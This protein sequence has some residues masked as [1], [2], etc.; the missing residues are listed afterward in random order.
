[1]EAVDAHA[2]GRP[3]EAVP[4][5]DGE[6][7]TVR[8][9]RE[10]L[11][12]LGLDQ[13]ALAQLR[14]VHVTGTKG[15]GSTCALVAAAL[16]AAG[17]PRVGLY[18]SP[19]LLDVRERIRVSGVPISR[20]AFARCYARVAGVLGPRG[21]LARLGY[22]PLLTVMA[23]EHFVRRRC[24]AV[25]L[26]VGVG[27]R[28]DATNVID[29]PAVC[30]VASLG[31]D[32]TAALG[33]TAADIAW[34]KA[35]IFRPHVPALSAPGQP[36]AAL[37]VL[38][39]RA[40]QAGTHLVVADS[41]A[42]TAAAAAAHMPGAFQRTNAALAAAIVRAWQQVQQ[43]QGGAVLSEEDVER[44]IAAALRDCVWPG[45]AQTLVYGSLT[46]R[47]DGAHTPESIAAC[48]EWFASSTA[49]ATEAKS[50]E[51]EEEES[52]NAL[53]FACKSDRAPAVLLGC[54]A[55]ACAAHG[56]VFGTVL[57]V[58]PQ[59]QRAFHSASTLQTAARAC[60]PACRDIRC[61]SSAEDALRM[62]Q[63]PPDTRREVLVTGSLY[64]VSDVL[65]AAHFA[66]A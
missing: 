32:H 18:T 28:T 12:A 3:S 52:T 44:G 9:V 27:G 53:V 38:Q 19:H 42:S 2:S 30:A 41:D 5:D 59:P 56:V 16:Q 65:R 21:L 36:P 4:R 45:R 35:G 63:Q 31:L 66:L 25:V 54:L 62:L 23:L 47:I 8:L 7:P 37:R 26:E 50:K 57:C 1:M 46:L 15:K 40:T 58:Q 22:F 55:Q 11:A 61:S 10:C 51:E 24:G 6:G 14:V 43:Q 29:R 49:G 17:V 20:G 34:E 64:L 13:A 60:L 33:T 48:V 39:E